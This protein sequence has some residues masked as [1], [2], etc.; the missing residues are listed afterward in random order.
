MRPVFDPIGGPDVLVEKMIGTAYE[1]VKRVYC[2][3]PEIRRLDGVLAEIPTLANE[4]VSQ[5]FAS[6]LPA[7]L[8]EVDNKAVIAV[9][10]RLEESLPPIMGNIQEKVDE[11]AVSASSAEQSAQASSD[12]SALSGAKAND[13]VIQAQIAQSA[14]ISAN[15]AKDSA[16][17][18]AGIKDSI[19]EG[20]ATTE[21]G[22]NFQVLSPSAVEYVIL[23]KNA[24]GGVATP[25]DSYP[26]AKAIT[27]I[28]VE[29]QSA[30][31]SGLVFAVVDENG[32]RTWLE[33]G[34]DGN[35]SPRSA[36]AMGNMLT[37][38]NS[39]TLASDIIEA[40]V[41]AAVAT[42][43]LEPLPDVNNLLLTVV[44]EG[45]KR[46]WLEVDLAGKPSKYAAQCI[47]DSLPADVG[48]AP[49]RYQSGI[50]GE[51]GITSGPN[52]TCWGDSMTAGAGGGGTTYP[53][54]LQ[55]LLTE[56]GQNRTVTNRGIGGESAPT[57]CARA[58]GNPFIVLAVGGVIPATTTPFE[59]TIQ[60]NNGQPIKPLMQGASS[61][62]GRFGSVK[63]TF[64]RTVVDTVYTYYFTRAVAGD[65]IVA[66]RPTPL[67]L[68]IGDQ[69]RGDITIIWIGQNGPNDVR[70]IQDAKAIIQR[71]T[72]LDKR[73]L[74]ISKPGGSSTSDVDDAAW[75]AEFGRRFIPIRQYMAKYG[76]ADAG[77][78]PTEGDLADMARGAVPGSLR[79]DGVHWNAPGYIILANIV[80][81]RLKELEWI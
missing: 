47:L 16:V 69:A 26:N 39:P 30:Q 48:S 8:E 68:D 6:Q 41:I 32:K 21:T 72:A 57:I 59:I 64:S 81:Q 34:L 70:A 56:A 51:Q 76:L 12:S 28:G 78:I 80:F 10:E 55:R 35:P 33:A 11:A 67:Y 66:N 58:G 13:A 1:T 15:S 65:E 9:S 23:Y 54:E 5:E 74:V 45:G 63:G 77:I 18:S 79:F 4:S 7:V 14:A 31:A 38:E 71:M 43:G 19:A 52:I 42:V 29:D 49:S 36:S 25:L 17:I 73:Y 62:T 37:S 50:K 44:D 61:Y 3:L 75:F 20:L 40:S 60:A 24:G 46:T 27:D 2:H 22:E 53:G